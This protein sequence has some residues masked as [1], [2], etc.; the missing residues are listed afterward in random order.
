MTVCAMDVTL[1]LLS[2]A[3]SM[4]SVKIVEVVGGGEN[5]HLAMVVT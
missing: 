2:D 5:S 4:L 1:L 3:S